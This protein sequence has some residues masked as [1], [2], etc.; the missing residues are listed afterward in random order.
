MFDI[1]EF[2]EQLNDLINEN[3]NLREENFNLRKQVEEHR[4]WIDRQ[5]KQTQDSIGNI[6]NTLLNNLNE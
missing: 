5:Y 3:Q 2:A 1:I 6:F 4:L